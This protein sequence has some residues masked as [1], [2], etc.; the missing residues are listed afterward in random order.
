[1][2][3]IL[4]LKLI[5]PWRSRS[6][7]SQNNRDLNQGVLLPWTKF[8]D[9]SLNRWRVYRVDKQVI[10]THTQTQATTI[11]GG[12]NWPRVKMG[13]MAHQITSLTIRS[14]HSTVCSERRHQSSA[15]QAFVGEF[16][17]EFPAQRV[18]NAENVSIWWRHHDLAA[19]NN[20]RRQWVH[21]N[22]SYFLQ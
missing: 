22:S 14:I 11:P 12:Q 17:G 19:T 1:M 2:G 9:T 6:I 18:S 4:S 13:A 5:W 20:W 3:S 8:G 15:S 10:N 16:N 7:A 21:E